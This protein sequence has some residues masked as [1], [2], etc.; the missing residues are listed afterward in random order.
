MEQML[1][2][3]DWIVCQWWSFNSVYFGKHMTMK[4][5]IMQF[6]STFFSCL[7]VYLHNQQQNNWIEK[8]S[9]YLKMTDVIPKLSGNV[10]DMEEE[11][12]VA[13]ARYGLTR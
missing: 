1:V 6:A 7:L 11:M 9:K 5:L 3:L 10:N 2:T 13:S 4:F 8:K 12:L